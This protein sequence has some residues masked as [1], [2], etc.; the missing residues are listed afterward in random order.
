MGTGKGRKVGNARFRRRGW[1]VPRRLGSDTKFQLRLN[2]SKLPEK[3]FV[4]TGGGSL[5]EVRQRANHTSAVV[6]READAGLANIDV[7]GLIAGRR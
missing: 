1:E 3:D 5:L 7:E 6:C 4:Q 2:P